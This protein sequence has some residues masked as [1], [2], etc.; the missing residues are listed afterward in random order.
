MWKGTSFDCPNREISLLHTQASSGLAYGECNSQTVVARI[1]SVQDNCYTSQ[2]NVTVTSSLIGTNI[3]CLHDD[4]EIT[5]I[6]NVT[7][8]SIT[9]KYKCSHLLYC[10]NEMHVFTQT[11]A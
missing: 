7:V 4:V 9:G 11:L 3:E 6:G 10:K 5:M 8:D 2:L 1:V